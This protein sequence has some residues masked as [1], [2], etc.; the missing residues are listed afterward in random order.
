MRS[1]MRGWVAIGGRRE[2]GPER[3]AL[4]SF[5]RAARCSQGY[6]DHLEH[7]GVDHRAVRHLA[8]V[9]YTDKRSVFSDDIEPWLTGGRVADAAELITSSGS[10]GLFSLGVTSHS[11]RRT[12]ERAIDATLR[13]LGATESSPTLLLN[14]LPMGIT[15]PTRLATVATP[16]VH[17]E[18][19]TEL[20]GRAGRRFDRVVIASEPLFLKELAETALR[21]HGPEFSDR[22]VACFV[23]GEWVAESWRHYVA[24]LFGFAP[25]ERSRAGVLVS[26]GAAEAGLH[27]LTESPALR[28]LRGACDSQGGRDRMFGEDRGYTPL[29]LEWDDRRIHLEEREHADGARTLVA[30]SLERRLM[31]LVRYDLDD[32]GCILSPGHVNAAMADLGCDVRIDAPIAAVWGRRATRLQGEGWS[33]RPEAVKEGLFGTAAHAGTLTGRFRIGVDDGVPQVHVQ[34]RDGGRPAPRLESHLSEL[35]AATTG[36]PVQVQIHRYRDYPFHDA[37]DF[38]HKPAYV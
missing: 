28:A 4:R 12:Q 6:R 18:M 15:V 16:S 27:V 30:T 23:G 22:V 36:A 21:L 26:M 32:E 5:Q 13:A 14:C 34:L 3:A 2:A 29:L 10:S 7:H 33:L 17:V 11:E 9:P 25:D 24:G 35:I 1:T 20:L 8:E 31:P 38:Q 37:G 19:A